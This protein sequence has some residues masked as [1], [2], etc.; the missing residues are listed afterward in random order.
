TEA[1][2]GNHNRL[3]RFTMSTTGEVL[4]DPDSEMP[5]IT[6]YDQGDG[7]NFNDLHFG[8]DGYL[9]MSV[10]DEGDGGGGDDY[11]NGQ[12]IDKDY[13]SGMLR[14][15]V[16]KKPENLP[17]NPHPA[18][19]SNYFV[20]ADN[21]FVGA[22]NF[23][24][25]PVDPT[26]VRTEFYAVGLRN[27]WRFS[28]DA[29]TGWI[30]EGDVGQHDYE[31]INNIVK[32]GNYGWSFLEGERPGPA[33]SPPEWLKFLDPIHMYKPGFGPDQGYSII[34]G[35]FYRGRKLPALTGKYIF[36][37]YVSGNIWAMAFDGT[38][39]AGIELIANQRGIASFGTD[40]R[41]QDLLLVDHDRGKILRLAVADGS[42]G[43]IPA[44]LAETGLFAD[45]SQLEVAEGVVSYDINVPFWSD[46]ATKKRWFTIPDNEKLTFSA[47]GNWTFPQGTIWIKHF[48]I[49]TTKGDPATRKKLETRIIYKKED[50]VYGLTYKWDAT[51]TNATLVPDEGE[52]VV[53]KIN[54]NGEMRDQTWRYPSR[55]E[56]LACH[57][58]ASGYAPGFN[59]AQ[60]NKQLN[61]RAS[62]INQIEALAHAGYITNA[63]ESA[64]TLK[65]LVP[66]SNE[67]V[68]RE[69]RVRSWLAANCAQCHQPG[70]GV[71]SQWDARISNPLSHSGIINGTLFDIQGNEDMR[72]VV[73][74]EVENSMMHKRISVMG[75]KHMPP[76]GTYLLDTE[77]IN[78]V[79]DW[80]QQDLPSHKTFPQWQE[81][82]FS[83]TT[84]ADASDTADPDKDG[85]ANSLEFL[86]GTNP[87]KASETWKIELQKTGQPQ[88]QFW[89]AANRGFEV[90]YADDLGEPLQWKPLLTRENRPFIAKE[91]FLKTLPDLGP[92]GTRRFYRVRAYEP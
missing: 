61:G 29:V 64:I 58:A 50:G 5:L 23:N 75:P 70:T 15:D 3:S 88:L 65:A 44:T 16:D 28:F 36:G 7:H 10:G 31:E 59:T 48:D 49:E 63:P 20:P 25:N 4:A 86:L 17:P 83:S 39:K 47:L 67:T 42:G 2:E 45:A 56:C 19:H 35:T 79:R 71:Q 54:D 74:G 40:P 68:S 41:N 69:Y 78:M 11:H 38:N 84:S 14:I 80:I 18:T 57:T 46:N 22:T 91:G 52:D 27:P 21:P 66:L 32:G 81:H 8:P 90:E 89:Q 92:A 87:K 24:F 72:V 34:G 53:L 13:F 85:A 6:Q 60:L 33:G 9:Y 43:T 55:N 82:W 30:L 12:K 1:G 62:M 37:D 51:G 26:K 73:P 77:A 76:L